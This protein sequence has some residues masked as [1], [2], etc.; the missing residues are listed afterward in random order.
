MAEKWVKVPDFADVVV[1]GDGGSCK[2]ECLK[3]CSCTAYAEVT[4]IGCMVWKGD[5]VDVQ[6]FQK[7]GQTLNVRLAHSDLGKSFLVGFFFFERLKLVFW[8]VGCSFGY[9]FGKLNILEIAIINVEWTRL[10]L[11]VSERQKLV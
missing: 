8:L 11:C 3:N 7:G 1:V 4:G 6:H 2:E 5:L 9:V 10:L